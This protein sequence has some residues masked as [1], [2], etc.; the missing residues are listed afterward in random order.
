MMQMLERKGFIARQPSVPRSMR[1]VSSDL[2]AL[3]PP[4]IG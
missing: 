1:G 4:G 2:V 3:R